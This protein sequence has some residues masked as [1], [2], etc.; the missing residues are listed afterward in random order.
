MF[1]VQE[2]LIDLFH[3]REFEVVDLCLDAVH[4][5]LMHHVCI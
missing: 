1:F 2:F 4:S 5:S 3:H